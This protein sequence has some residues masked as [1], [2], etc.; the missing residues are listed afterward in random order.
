MAAIARGPVAAVSS[1]RSA[2]VPTGITR[3][4]E[5]IVARIASTASPPISPHSACILC[6]AMSA[7]FTGR[8]VPAPTCSVSRADPIPR[9][10]TSASSPSSKCSEAVGA[11]TA[12]DRSANTVW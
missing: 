8:N 6:P 5:A 12:P 3:P 9:A 10:A 2:V 1:S 7:T 4:P 11:A